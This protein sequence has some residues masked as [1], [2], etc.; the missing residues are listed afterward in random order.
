MF[1]ADLVTITSRGA[2]SCTL[3]VKELIVAGISVGGNKLRWTSTT[4][5]NNPLG[6]ALLSTLILTTTKIFSIHSLKYFTITDFLIYFF[7]RPF[8]ENK[9]NNRY[10][11]NN[12]IF[13]PIEFI[14]HYYVPLNKEGKVTS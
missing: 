2:T 6:S 12:Y 9:K 1:S 13:N 11:D 14:F 4:I 5:N 8:T 10:Y 3:Y 7:I